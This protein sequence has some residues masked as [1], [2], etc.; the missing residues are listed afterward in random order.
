MQMSIYNRKQWHALSHSLHLVGHEELLAT[1]SR[2]RL[3][4]SMAANESG[5]YP[6]A[7]ELVVI[8]ECFNQE[9]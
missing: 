6:P 5:Y 9:G 7:A 4:R 8:A 3:T 2:T 1:I